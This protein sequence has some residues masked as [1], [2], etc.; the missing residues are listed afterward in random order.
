MREFWPEK[1]LYAGCDICDNDLKWDRMFKTMQANND[2]H[3]FR[4]TRT[5]RICGIKA[6]LGPF[7]MCYVREI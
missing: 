2:S 3:Q 6:Y 1:T 7:E 4:G 5:C